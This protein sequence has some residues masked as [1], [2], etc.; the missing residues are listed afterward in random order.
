VIGGLNAISKWPDGVA[1]LA[2]IDVFEELEQLAQDRTVSVFR[3]Q[4]LRTILDK[5][6]STRQEN[7][8]TER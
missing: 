1:A 6:H 4:I 8:V 2:D 7:Y 5:L 3:T